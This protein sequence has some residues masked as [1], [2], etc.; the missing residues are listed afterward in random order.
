MQDIK[1]ITKAAV[2]IPLL[3]IC[4]SL[5]LWAWLSNTWL[6]AIVLFMMILLSRITS[7]R[8][9]ITSQQFYRWGDL[10]SV[11]VIFMVA[12]VYLLESAL[13]QP[14]FI[15]LKW[16][17]VLFS[18]VLFAQLFS[19]QQQLPLGTLLYSLRKHNNL[20]NV[21]NIDFQMP[22]A[23]LTLLATGAANTPGNI[24]YLGVIVLFSGMLLMTRPAQG[25]KIIWFILLSIAVITGYLGHKGLKRLHYWVEEQSIEWVTSWNTNPFKTQTSIG[26]LGQLKLSDKIEFRVKADAPLLLHQASYNVYMGQS[27]GTSAR[28]FF[29]DNPVK[30]THNNLVQEIKIIQ[31]FSGEKILALPDGTINL[32]GLEG[33]SLQYNRF[34]TVKIKNAPPLGTY[35]VFYTGRREGESN[36]NDLTV[37]EL[38]KDWLVSFSKKL[39]LQGLNTKEI[40]NRIQEYFQENFY[41]SLYLGNESDANIALKNFIQKR[42]AGHCEYFAVAS[43]L[44]LRYAG[45]PARLANGYMVDEYNAKQDLYIVRRRHAHA[46]AIAYIDGVWLPVDSTPSQWL[47]IEANNAGWMQAVNDW[48]DERLLAFKQWR[49]QQMG[50]NNQWL[51][52]AGILLLLYL[53]WRIYSAKQQLS[54]KKAFVENSHKNNKQ[55]QN[56]EFYLIVQYFQNT[57]QARHENESIQQWINRINLSELYPLYRLHYQ[58]RFDPLGISVEKR[59]NLQQHVTAWLSEKQKLDV[60]TQPQFLK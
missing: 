47:Q 46:W 21:R 38:H 53:I 3:F 55:G 5:S 49:I 44:L 1:Y 2:L 30:N 4:F 27:W 50:K 19:E 52:I 32:K 14:I 17:P 54:R 13:N 18:P 8:W 37:P 7:L 39:H 58:L 41:Y 34:G 31:E 45:I 36:I 16:L 29:E 20:N 60:T 42:K 23:A 22:Y 6:A 28:I 15:V 43:V 26:D 40:A 56:S 10:C 11:L 57:A 35:Q 9:K 12:Y 25:S 24:Y 33:A 51:W 59:N 48:I